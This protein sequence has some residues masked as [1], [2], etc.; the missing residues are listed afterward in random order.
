[1]ARSSSAERVYAEVDDLV[2]SSEVRELQ[3]KGF[4]RAL[5]AHNIVGLNA[6]PAHA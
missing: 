3:L 1:M 4:S 6:A 2:A 5:T